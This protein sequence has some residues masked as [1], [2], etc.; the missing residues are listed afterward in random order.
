MFVDTQTQLELLFTL[1]LVRYDVGGDGD[2]DNDNGD[3]AAAADDVG[4]DGDSADDDVVVSFLCVSEF[5]IF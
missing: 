4:G 1:P 5:R 2:N 3:A